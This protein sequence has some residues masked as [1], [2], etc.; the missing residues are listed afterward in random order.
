ME[1]QN[2]SSTNNE[3]VPVENP[4]VQTTDVVAITT[5]EASGVATTGEITVVDSL[6]TG[7]ITHHSVLSDSLDGDTS[8]SDHQLEVDGVIYREVKTLNRVVIQVSFADN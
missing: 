2:S 6:T 1:N 8:M 5:L 7:E 4:D 3:Q